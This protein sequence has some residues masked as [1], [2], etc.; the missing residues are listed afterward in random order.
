MVKG[1]GVW[2]IF[3]LHSK[4]SEWPVSTIQKVFGIAYSQNHNIRT[5]QYFIFIA[6]NQLLKNYSTL[7]KVVGVTKLLNEREKACSF[8]LPATCGEV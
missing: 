6:D 3:A 7:A 1:G 5:G 2:T 4:R 8:Y